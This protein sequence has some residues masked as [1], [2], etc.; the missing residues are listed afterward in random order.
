MSVAQINPANKP[1]DAL[2]TLLW[3][4]FGGPV[5]YINGKRTVQP[6]AVSSDDL[7]RWF[8]EQ[9]LDSSML[10]PQ[11]RR[12]DKFRTVT[13][14]ARHRYEVTGGR[15]ELYVE[16]VE[17]D[18]NQ[19]VRNVMRRVTDDRRQTIVDH[20]ATLK[21]IRGGRSSK[22]RRTSGDHWR[23]AI[24]TRVR[25]P[26]R[27]EVEG[28]INRIDAAYKEGAEALDSTALR[29]IVRRYLLALNGVPLRS[30]GGIYF[31]P[32]G[33]DSVIP[34]LAEVIKRIGSPGCSLDYIPYADRPHQRDILAEAFQAEVIGDCGNLQRTIDARRTAA[35]AKGGRLAPGHYAEMRARIDAILATVEIYVEELGLALG[36]AGTAI[37]Q[38][39]DRLSELNSLSLRR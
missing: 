6:V 25:E 13:S 32:A 9:G 33:A 37:E 28:F 29:V 15:A 20:V 38:T 16:E 17:F 11:V 36:E 24:L 26:D 39:I 4:A 22:Q 19:V 21:F 18:T 35:E 8:D 5:E 7:Y 14:N 23:W 12:I 31:V 34:G 30:S 10:P 2:G 27:T 1:A 3:F